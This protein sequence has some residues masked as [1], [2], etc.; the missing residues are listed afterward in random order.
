MNCEVGNVVSWK[1]EF[2]EVGSPPFPSPIYQIQ[3]PAYH[4]T[5]YQDHVTYYMAQLENITRG[6]T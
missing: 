6:R 4:K 1:R 3:K 2:W 5:V